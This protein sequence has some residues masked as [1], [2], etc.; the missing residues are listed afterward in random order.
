MAQRLEQWEAVSLTPCPL[1]HPAGFKPRLP[2]RE[3]RVQQGGFPDI[4]RT[5]YP[6]G[7]CTSN[8]SAVVRLHAS[9]GTCAA[10]STSACSLVFQAF[11]VSRGVHVRRQPHQKLSACR[12]AE[13]ARRARARACHVFSACSPC[14]LTTRSATARCA[15][16]ASKRLNSETGASTRLPAASTSRPLDSRSSGVSSARPPLIYQ[17]GGVSV[18][19]AVKRVRGAPSPQLPGLSCLSRTREGTSPRPAQEWRHTPTQAHEGE[20]ASAPPSV[21]WVQQERSLCRQLRA[22]NTV[23][24]STLRAEIARH[25]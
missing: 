10:A 9:S 7:S 22:C 25:Y 19:L 6:R 2:P 24:E 13:A 18:S 11:V 21:E 3:E 16:R 17:S 5:S 12:L 8:S 15:K 1:S 14:G 20:C 23:L 4:V